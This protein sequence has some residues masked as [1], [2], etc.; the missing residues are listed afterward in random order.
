MLAFSL[1]AVVF[2]LPPVLP[3]V[4]SDLHLSFAEAGALT[5]IVVI[6]LSLGAIPGAMLSNR[7]GSTRS[8]GL[9]A[10]ALVAGGIVRTL[11]P[12]GFWLPVGTGLATLGLAASQP[13]MIVLIGIRFPANVQRATTIFINA[14]QAGS[15]AGFA[16]TPLLAAGLGWRAALDVWTALALISALTWMRLVKR[17]PA[18]RIG[19]VQDLRG[20]LRDRNLWLA[21]AIITAQSTTFFTVAAWLPFL[22]L[23]LA[24]A[25]V[26][27]VFFLFNAVAL[28]PTLLAVF[29]WRFASSRIYYVAA[30]L[31]A[32]AGAA[33]MLLGLRQW[34]WIAG[35]GVGLGTTMCYMGIV[36]IIPHLARQREDVATY[37]AAVLSVGYVGALLGPLAGGFIVDATKRVNWSFWPA[38]VSGAFMILF[39]LKTATFR[40]AADGPPVA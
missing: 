40:S 29:R 21:S 23:G 25:Y 17:E 9:G 2:S 8:I 37:A 35:L 33:T 34:A 38:V 1:R 3:P 12:G 7:V 39:G 32:G 31:M 18:S 30:G 36:A 28:V 4:R 5:S 14:Q 27:V 15:L 16:L 24:S 22:L 19:R 26:I 10:C 6:C 11:P 20:L 13:A